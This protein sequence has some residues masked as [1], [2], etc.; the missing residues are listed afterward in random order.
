M[1]PKRNFRRKPDNT[2][3]NR[4]LLQDPETKGIQPSDI[5][6]NQANYRWFFM[7]VS[8][9]HQMI[10]EEEGGGVNSFR[11]AS[12]NFK[13]ALAPVKHGVKKMVE[14]MVMR[15]MDKVAMGNCMMN[16]LDIMDAEQYVF[17][18]M[19]HGTMQHADKLMKMLQELDEEVLEY[20]KGRGVES[21]P[22]SV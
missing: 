18:I 7:M 10:A 14:Y 15:G 4:T 1:P 2:P 17:Q 6:L 3:G 12:L 8:I 16:N 21:S 11:T 19:T 5:E 9:L 13:A 22:E 20:Q